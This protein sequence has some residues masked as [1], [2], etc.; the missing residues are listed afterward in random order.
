MCLWRSMRNTSP[1]TGS[2]L[3]I[4]ADIHGLAGRMGEL[5][6]LLE[7]LAAA[8]REEPQ[9][10]DFRVLAS[11]EPAEFVLLSSW[12]EEAALASTTRHRTTATTDAR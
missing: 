8:S 4:A 2:S 11:A 3:L 12:S 10:L 9:C 1:V 5:R 6:A 7:E